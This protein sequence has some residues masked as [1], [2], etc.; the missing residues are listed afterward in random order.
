MRDLWAVLLQTLTASGAAVLLLVVKAIFRD[1]L[2]PRWQ[3]GIWGVLGL[4]LLLPAGLLGRYVLVNWPLAVETVKTLLTGS[5]TLTHVIN[6]YLS[7]RKLLQLTDLRPDPRF[8]CRTAGS[9]I[10]VTAFLSLY[11]PDGTHWTGL[12]IRGGLYLVLLAM[13]LTLT[14]TVDKPGKNL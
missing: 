1:K 2:S 14:G 5:Y 13:L 4:I 11:L 3:F 9:V 8:L 7:V 10:A 12:L 6:F